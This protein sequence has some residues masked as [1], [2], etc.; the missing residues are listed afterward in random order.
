MAEKLAYRPE[1]LTELLPLGRTKIFNLIASGEIES[2]KVGRARLIPAD[3]L[4]RFIE[5]KLGEKAPAV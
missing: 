5:R 4:A 1:E 3:A 2:I